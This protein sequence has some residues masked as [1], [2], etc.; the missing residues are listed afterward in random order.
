MSIRLPGEGVTYFIQG[1]KTE[2]IKIGISVKNCPCSRYAALQASSPDKLL[3]LGIIRGNHERK[4]HKMFLEY[5]SHGEWFYPNPKLL[6]FISE[7][8]QKLN[9]YCIDRTGYYSRTIPGGFGS[10]EVGGSAEQSRHNSAHRGINAVDCVYCQKRSEW[11]YQK[12]ARTKKRLNRSRNSLISTIYG[13]KAYERK[14][15]LDIPPLGV[16]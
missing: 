11:S 6:D 15:T 16:V 14:K 3:I 10:R 2:L 9:C 12:T 8:T 1:E 5:W 7:E 13:K 4:L